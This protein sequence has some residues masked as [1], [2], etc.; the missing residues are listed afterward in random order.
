MKKILFLLLATTALAQ[1]KE[2]EHYIAFSAAVDIRNATSGSSLTNDKPALD[3]LYQFAM[4][5]QNFEVNIGY[6]SFNAI[7]FEKYT[8]GVGYHFTLYGYVFDKEIKTILIP[9]IEPTIIGRW[10]G[11]WQCKSSHLSVG[12]NIA[13]RW[14]LS[15]KTAVE[16][17]CNALPRTDL[18]SRYPEVNSTAPIIISNY[19]KIIYKL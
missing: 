14:H 8:V 10:G 9:S 1:P 2:Y 7:C 11:E 19:V 16:L 13:L 3:L 15:D 4:V 18:S 5:G 12:G 17:L 6:E